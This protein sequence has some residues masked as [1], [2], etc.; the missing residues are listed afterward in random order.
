MC[1]Y[2]YAPL[3]EINVPWQVIFHDLSLIWDEGRLSLKKP[4]SADVEVVHTSSTADS[5]H[6]SDS[7]SGPQASSFGDM[8]KQWSLCQQVTEGHRSPTWQ[9][10]VRWMAEKYGPENKES[11]FALKTRGRRQ[12]QRTWWLREQHAQFSFPELQCI[13]LDLPSNSSLTWE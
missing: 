1:V 4:Q 9:A 12:R 6:H 11:E 5:L 8:W 7:R 13:N 10:C 3:E 2:V